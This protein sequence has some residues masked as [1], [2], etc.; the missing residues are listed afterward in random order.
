MSRAFGLA[1]ALFN[2]A[3]RAYLAHEEADRRVEAFAVFNIFY[4]TGILIGP[5]VG[6]LLLRMDFRLVCLSASAIFATLT[7]GVPAVYIGMR[8]APKIA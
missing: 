6:V 4:Q 3:A 2:P 8:A 5:L 1:G 7:G